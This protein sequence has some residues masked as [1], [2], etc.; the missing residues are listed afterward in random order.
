MLTVFIK[1]T[2]PSYT[3]SYCICLF[4]EGPVGPPWFQLF[5]TSVAVDHSSPIIHNNS[6]S[7]VPSLYLDSQVKVE[8]PV[9]QKESG[10]RA[11][12]Q[13]DFLPA[14][15]TAAAACNSCWVRSTDQNLSGG[16]PVLLCTLTVT[17]DFFLDQKIA[18]WQGN[19]KQITVFKLH[20]LWIFLLPRGWNVL[21]WVPQWP[22]IY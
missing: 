16:P 1:P 13:N 22:F 10:Q 21:V 19:L 11:A 12:S 4:W 8:E 7:S 9:R 6:L 5:V 2:F 20:F 17:L 18:P 15:W 14:V 3:L